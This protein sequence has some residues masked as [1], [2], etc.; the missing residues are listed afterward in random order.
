MIGNRE[1][2]IKR[3]GFHHIGELPGIL[4]QTTDRPILR[5]YISKVVED[6]DEIV[7]DATLS[8]KKERGA[9]NF[10]NLPNPCR[11]CPFAQS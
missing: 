10:G 9:F 6:R 1:F 5:R 4:E 7:V 11:P 8:W 3:S 2:V